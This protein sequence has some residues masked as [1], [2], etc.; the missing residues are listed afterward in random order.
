MTAAAVSRLPLRPAPPH[1]PLSLLLAGWVGPDAATGWRVRAFDQA[2]IGAAS[3][4]LVLAPTPSAERRADEPSGSFGGLRPPINV[5][6]D[7]QGNVVLLDPVSG[8]VLRFDACDCRFVALRC[9]TRV[10]ST[11]G[12]DACTDRTALGLPGARRVPLG[13]LR[14]PHGIALCNGELYVAD[15]GHARVV[16]MTLHSG[17]PH[18]ELRLPAAER[19]ARA[20]PWRP[21][22]LAFDG[23]GRLYVTDP[24]N[25]RIDM[26]DAH[27]RWL[28]ALATTQPVWHVAVDCT[29]RVHAVLSQA[30]G[31]QA[32][33]GAGGAVQWQWVLPPGAPSGLT[34][35]RFDAE[36]N[37]LA[38]DLRTD[39]LEGFATLPFAVDSD[40]TI[41]LPC[42]EGCGMFDARGTTLPAGARVMA[43]RYRRRG[44]YFSAALDS[45][46]E[47][48]Q[49][50]RIELRGCLPVG[51]S[52]AVRTLCAEI[53][54][55][56]NELALLPDSAWS[57]P[58]AGTAMADGR[59]DALI[60]STPG[61]YA[62][63]RIDL[64]GDG[65]ETPCIEAA[66]IEYPRISLRRYLP[67]VYGAEHLSADFTD[68]FLALFDTSLRSIE[69]HLDRGAAL[70]D[71]LSAPAQRVGGQIDFLSWLA[72]WIGLAMARDWPVERRRRYLKAAARLYCLRGTPQGLRDQLL[73]LLGFEQAY[74]LCPDERPR[75]RCLPRPRNCGPCPPL[76]PAQPPA[77]LLEH[78]KLRRWLWA[79]RSRLGNDSV[80]WGRRIVNRSQL[81]GDEPP[82]GHSGNAQVGVSQLISTPDPLRDPLLVH[83]NTVSVFVPASVRKPGA[84][85]RALQQLL[86]R[87]VPAHVQV[88]LHHVEPRFRV[89]V[90]AMV[91]LDSVIARTPR[92]VSLN[93]N[94]LGSG[95][96]LGGAPGRPR[97]PGLEVGRSRVGPPTAV[98]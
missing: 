71:P 9:F 76:T 77:L 42:R 40:G 25:R 16:R 30:L 61:R 56:N 48:C 87:E 94:A 10:A 44:S 60:R 31:L 69:G 95:T 29:D 37:A 38:L 72:S 7:A 27:G 5:A 39:Q 6:V 15:S 92:G 2:E 43:P 34:L 78:F 23:Q 93:D 83:A 33:A 98:G 49:W 45:R 36:G 91:G 67:A 3:G 63:L 11:D 17:M 58:V 46:I 32:V 21:T 84:D 47:G 80:L 12:T 82:P 8:Q 79:G 90:Q 52:V 55:D 35:V 24:L 50:H 68:R 18:G 86:Q 53:E 20:G 73:L 1:D 70:F 81:S 14:D 88:V 41:H 89:G 4:A 74:G 28:R 75:T 65:Y 26:F 13:E 51:S 96:V 64:A 97:S 59:W 85:Q 66:L 19:A 22:S 57:E 62:W 54:F